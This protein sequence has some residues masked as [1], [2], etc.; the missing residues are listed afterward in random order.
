MTKDRL[1]KHKE[2]SKKYREKI[3]N[4]TKKFFS[5][6]FSKKEGE[7]IKKFIK[8]YNVPMKRLIEEGTELMWKENN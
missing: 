2:Y 3:L 7:E 1:L 4:K 5:V 6:R 8:E